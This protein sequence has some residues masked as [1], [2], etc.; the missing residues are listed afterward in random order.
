MRVGVAFTTALPF[1]NPCYFGT[2]IDSREHLIACNHTH[3]EITKMID[4][5]SLGY[6]SISGV[7]Q[8][9]N[10]CNLTFCTGCFTGEYP[11]PAPKTTEKRKY[12]RKINEKD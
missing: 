8:M 1:L 6:L 7:K 5:D 4:A 2:D 11:T 12:E 3:E 10:D 9:A